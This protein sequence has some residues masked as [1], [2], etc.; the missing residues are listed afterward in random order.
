MYT[1]ACFVEAEKCARELGIRDRGGYFEASKDSADDAF[2]SAVLDGAFHKSILL[3]L[4]RDVS[5]EM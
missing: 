1:A 2:C 4:V 3:R 5:G